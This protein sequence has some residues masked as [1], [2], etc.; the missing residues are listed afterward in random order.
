MLDALQKMEKA[1][2]N[3]GLLVD[4]SHGNSK[5]QALAQTQIWEEILEFHQ[6]T[7]PRVFGAMLESFLE[8]GRQDL[9]PGQSPLPGLSI[10]DACLGWIETERLI[11][12]SADTLR[13]QDRVC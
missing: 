12:K 7:E 5:K 11:L 1:G 4:C 9:Q 3:P 8:T 2:L 10:T 6:N 13:K